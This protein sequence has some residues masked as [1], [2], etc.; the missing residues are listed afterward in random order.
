[1]DDPQDDRMLDL[2]SQCGN[3]E[4]I[5]VSD[6]E[7]CSSSLVVF[8]T[9]SSPRTSASRSSRHCS[10][11]RQKLILEWKREIKL[12]C[13]IEWQSTTCMRS[14]LLHDRVIKLW[15]K[16]NMFTQIP[17]SVFE[18]CIPSHWSWMS[19]KNPE[20]FQNSNEYWEFFGIDR[21]PFEFEWNIFP[22]HTT[23]QILQEIHL[24]LEQCGIRPLVFE[25]RIIFM[26]FFNDID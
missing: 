15:K 9:C 10:M 4:K 19:G 14:I 12:I 6:I 16:Q 1:M 26:S 23:V 20:Y 25:D 24:K 8:E 22:R 2:K 18:R 5:H 3:L 17:C 13:T 7:G 11:S 21:E